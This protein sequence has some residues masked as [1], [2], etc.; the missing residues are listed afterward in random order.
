MRI[1]LAQPALFE[2]GRLGLENMIWMSEPV[3]LTAVA[4]AVIGKGTKCESSICASKKRRYSPI[5]CAP[6]SQ[7]S[8]AS[9]A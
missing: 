1:L 9:P 3:A 7:T 2:K 6:S 4:G 5:P 8:S